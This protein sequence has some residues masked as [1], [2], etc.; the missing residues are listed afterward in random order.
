MPLCTQSSK[1]GMGPKKSRGGSFSA[2]KLREMM[3]NKVS[4]V[5]YWKGQG[6]WGHA[7]LIRSSAT[8]R[9]TLTSVSRET[10][11]G[12]VTCLGS[13]SPAELGCEHG[14]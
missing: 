2:P 3:V 9:V 14:P 4:G 12:K 11:R 6:L 8:L 7:D 1:M 13:H 10:Q 5:V